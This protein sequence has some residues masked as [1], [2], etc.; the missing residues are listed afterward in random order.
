MPTLRDSAQDQI[1][2]IL[3]KYPNKRSAVLPLCH[4]ARQTYGYMSAEAVREVA[5]ILEIDPTEVSGLVS[6]YTLL[7]EN[8]TGKFIL[9]ICNDLPCALRGADRFVGHVCEKLDVEVGETTEDGLF[10]VET[11]MCIAACDRAPAAQIDLEYHENLDPDKFDRIVDL[12]RQKEHSDAD[13]TSG[14]R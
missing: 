12:M 14:D 2:T 7:R 13:K 3:A 11:V 4:L 1:D 8:S 10:T 5:T 9:E 6:F